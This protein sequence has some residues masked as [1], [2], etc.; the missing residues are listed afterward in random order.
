[1]EK[2]TGPETSGATTLKQ[3][4]LWKAVLTCWEAWGSNTVMNLW[5]IPRE[6]VVVTW[7]VREKESLFSCHS[8][9]L[10]LPSDTS[11]PD[12]VRRVIGL[13]K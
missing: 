13:V 10:L 11:D 3:R 5:L 9:K 8:L 6:N 12:V 2:P 7:M 1:M 4:S